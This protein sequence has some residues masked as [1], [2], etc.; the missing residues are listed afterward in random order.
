MDQHLQLSLRLTLPAA[1]A[2]SQGTPGFKITGPQGG[3]GL[4]GVREAGGNRGGTD[5]A[6]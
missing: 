5:A 2:P 6:R 3:E 1:P 4:G